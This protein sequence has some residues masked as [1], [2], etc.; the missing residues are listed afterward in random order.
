MKIILKLRNA[1]F[2]DLL[3]VSQVLQII[4]YLTMTLVLVSLWLFVIVSL[5]LSGTHN[6]LA[7]MV[8][9]EPFCYGFFFVFSS[10]PF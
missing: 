6:A 1:Y 4:C 5:T 9:L 3:V 10:I 2:F 8:L 7:L